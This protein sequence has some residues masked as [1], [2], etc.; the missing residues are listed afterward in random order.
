M[1]K[2]S[3]AITNL[4]LVFLFC[5]LN[6]ISITPTSQAQYSELGVLDIDDDDL[7]VGTDIFSDFNEDLEASQVLED[8]RFYRFGRFYSFNTSAGVTSYTGNRGLAYED[9]HPSLGISILYFLN[10]RMAFGLGAEYS[11]HY[12]LI[13]AKTQKFSED[14]GPGAIEVNMFRTF[15]FYRYYID[16]A[17]LGTAITYANPYFV[18]RAEFW[19][20]TNKFTDH[21]DIPNDSGGAIG[22]AIGVG[23]EFPIKF[24]ESYLGVEVLYHMINFKDTYDRAAYKSLD[25]KK[26]GGY[27]NLEGDVLTT[28]VS[29]VV[30]W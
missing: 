8:E 28:F 3:K 26:G 24:K 13:D 14:G 1:K 15:L 23:L 17:E 12:M 7:T 25:D 5:C 10:F 21:S 2:R 4:L 27:D 16:T 20:Q 22:G 11:K 18:T 9:K 6:L 29:Y 19:N 30:S